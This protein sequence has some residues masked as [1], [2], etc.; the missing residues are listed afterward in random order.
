[1]TVFDALADPAANGHV[2]AKV[3][4]QRPSNVVLV[5]PE[6][7][8]VIVWLTVAFGNQKK[9]LAEASFTRVGGKSRHEL[10]FE[11]DPSDAGLLAARPAGD[12]QLDFAEDYTGLFHKDDLM[13][14]TRY[15]REAITQFNNVVLKNAPP[16]E[17]AV[18]VR[19][20]G[21]VRQETGFRQYVQ[22][23]SEVDVRIARDAVLSPQVI[24]AAIGD[25]IKTANL[26]F[27]NLR[28]LAKEKETAVLTFVFGNGM[29]V[30]GTLGTFRSIK[31]EDKALLEKLMERRDTWDNAREYFG[32][33]KVEAEVGVVGL[34]EVKGGVDTEFGVKL[35]DSGSAERKDFSKEVKELFQAVE[36][37]LPV[38]ALDVGQL[39]KAA[40]ADV[41]VNRLVLGTFIPGRQALTH[42]V[43]FQTLP[44]AGE[45]F[46]PYKPEL[47]RKVEDHLK[48]MPKVSAVSFDG[49]GKVL[50]KTGNIDKV[51]KMRAGVYEVHFRDKI[52]GV[53]YALTANNNEGSCFFD[54]KDKQEAKCVVNSLDRKGGH[55]SSHV[56]LIVAEFPADK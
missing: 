29:T 53:R 3:K 48:S 46:P 8:T 33:L 2:I 21:G 31:S 49:E 14:T 6:R 50:H 32:K 18:L 45:L 22:T 43:S 4:G 25:A 27:T 15:T 41:N 1:V 54:E 10:V 37:E 36:G 7:G 42:G 51:V 47:V 34:A 35:R 16:G 13:V 17:K 20:G 19:F 44:G 38:V 28:T 26:T 56:D 11:I 30:R 39:Q 40:A 23:A 9:R 12:F 52:P 5:E 55:S 24:E